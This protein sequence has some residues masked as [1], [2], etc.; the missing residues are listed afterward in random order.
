MK[1]ASQGRHLCF[2]P[3]QSLCKS[4]CAHDIILVTI[5][6]RSL[7]DSF[8]IGI[9]ILSV[10]TGEGKGWPRSARHF[11]ASGG[12]LRRFKIWVTLARDTPSL[13]ESC[14]PRQVSLRQSFLPFVRQTDRIGVTLTG[15]RSFNYLKFRRFSCVCKAG[16]FT[17]EAKSIAQEVLL[18]V[19]SGEPDCT[20]FIFKGFFIGRISTNKTRI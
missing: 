18:S 3:I 2:R 6:S 20:T 1:V 4:F 13:P 19:P 5:D 10:I 11:K 15:L 12:S 7:N 16:F 8:T 14:H 17:E 9:S